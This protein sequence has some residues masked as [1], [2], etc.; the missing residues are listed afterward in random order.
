MNG[1][2]M[3]NIQENETSN[4]NNNTNQNDLN[5]V[6]NLL[7]SNSGL[8]QFQPNQSNTNLNGNSI[9]NLLK[10]ANNLIANQQRHST[11]GGSELMEGIIAIA[12]VKRQINSTSLTSLEGRITYQRNGETY[13]IPYLLNDVLPNSL[14]GQLPQLKI[15][16]RVRFSI[17]QVQNQQQQQI[18]YAT[19]SLNIPI[20]TVYARRVELIIQSPNS[21]LLSLYNSD[22][23]SNVNRKLYR[24]II[25]S[26]KDTFGKI[27]REDLFKETFFH[28]NDYKGKNAHQELRL[29]LNVEFEIQDRYGKEIACNIRMLPEGT[30][31]FDDISSTI[32]V[33]RIIQP[34]MLTSSSNSSSSSTP[35]ISIGSLIFDYNDDSNLI[36]LKFTERDR[37]PECGKYTLLEG[38]FVQF[39]IATDKRRMINSS[40]GNQRRATQISLIEEHSLSAN[41]QN[42]KEHREKGVLIKL[43]S[44]N[45]LL[46]LN[47][48][49]TNNNSN[50][51]FL[52]KINYGAIKCIEQDE[53]IYFSFNEIINYAKFTSNKENDNGSSSSQQIT[54]KINQ[55]KLELGDSLEFSVVECSSNSNNNSNN[56]EQSLFKNGLK[57][58]RVCQL[59]RNTV[60]FHLITDDLV[61]GYVEKEPLMLPNSAMIAAAA[62]S[63]RYQ[64]DFDNYSGSIIYYD[65]DN[66]TKKSVYFNPLYQQKV[67]ESLNLI[68][69]NGDKDSDSKQ[70][71]PISNI[72]L[73]DKIQ[74]NLCTCVRTQKKFAVNIKLVESRKEKGFVTMLK[75]N[76]GFIEINLFQEKKASSNGKSAVSRD[77]FFHFRYIFDNL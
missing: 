40:A 50:S 42:T 66:N 63:N 55:V 53:I 12:A 2:K 56:N 4:N 16:D 61:T 43:L 8:N 41:S 48:G 64:D 47:S 37:I 38:D 14:N 72:Y 23:N 19:T 26:L 60:R 49:T 5:S 34:P 46:N 52:N 28:F 45:D 39:R 24:G 3:F 6:I 11:N 68:M 70:I 32:Y 75:D 17:A 1:L 21:S 77:I 15:G 33:G 44:A 57:A 31:T 71:S 54:Y 36:E 13:Y 65:D 73:G 67:N 27:E 76:Y 58:I 30:V 35:P 69:N 22:N 29:G 10:N 7:N 20:G 18:I 74:F 9:L 25:S 51:E 59:A 62:E